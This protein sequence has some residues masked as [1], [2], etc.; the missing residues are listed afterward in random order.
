MAAN[1]DA[2]LRYLSAVFLIAASILTA[3]LFFLQV[4]KAEDYKTQANRQYERPAGPTFDRGSIYFTNRDGQEVSAA[5]L[6]TG[7][8]LVINPTKL[9][10][11]EAVYGALNTVYPLDYVNFIARAGK[12]NDPHEEVGSRLTA[13]QAKTVSALNL[14][15]VGLIEQ[16]WRFYPGGTLAAHLLGF[17]G[18]QGNDYSGRYGLEK[19]YDNNLRREEPLSFS[20][21]LGRIFLGLAEPAS[22]TN[23]PGDIVTTVEPTVQRFLEHELESVQTNWQ[24]TLTGGIIIDPKTGAIISLAAQPTFDPG[25]KQSDV[26]RLTNP[27]VER[28]YEMGSIVKPL[29]IGAGLDAKVITPTTTYDDQGVIAFGDREIGNY[30][31]RGRGVVSMQEVLNQS[32]NT[33]V[34]YVMQQLGGARLAKYFQDFGL[35]GEKTGVDLPGESGGLADNLKSRRAVEYATA[36]FGQGFANTPLA[37]TA[38]LSTLANG[39]ALV[40]PFVVQKIV[41]ETKLTKETEPTI[42]RQVISPEAASTTTAMLVQVVDKAL[43]GGKERLAHYRVAAK[44]GTAQIRQPGGGYYSD[45][46]LHS[47]FGYFPASNPRFTIFLYAVAPQ[48]AEYASATLAKP[49]FN[50]VKFLLNYYQIPPDR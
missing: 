22:S 16:K 26:E 38:A 49:F 44:T 19:Y 17:V 2:R 14:T 35:L 39:G 11:P 29:T 48:G 25:G 33:G 24:P 9:Q 28:V 5:T 47:F 45:R 50:L 23:Q 31:R 46:Y 18:Y 20:N 12:N 36:S 37:I 27:L 43:L 1:S 7:Y 42:R 8:S 15:G 13:N 34:V 30:D 40:R 32:L 21:F 6:Q 3:K 10:D 4:I 41:Y